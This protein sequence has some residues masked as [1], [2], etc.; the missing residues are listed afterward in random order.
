MTHVYVIFW[1]LL[2]CVVFNYTTFIWIYRKKYGAK[3]FK[4][5]LNVHKNIDD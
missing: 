2:K 4:T 5:F 3:Q 1:I